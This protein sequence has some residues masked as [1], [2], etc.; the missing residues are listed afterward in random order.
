MLTKHLWELHFDLSLV[1]IVFPV[2]QIILEIR[3]KINFSS[4]FTLPLI[5]S[6]QYDV[7]PD[8]DANG[9]LQE[10]FLLC[11][12][13]TAGMM[14]DMSSMHLTYRNLQTQNALSMKVGVYAY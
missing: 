13:C 14:H 7:Q 9:H 11:S 6:Q 4:R 2:K 8:N 1:P 12:F 3:V 10:H 5:K